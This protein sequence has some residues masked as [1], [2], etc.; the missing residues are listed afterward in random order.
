VIR[1]FFVTLRRSQAGKPYFHR[2]VLDSLGLRRRLACTE[3]P[4]NSIIRGMLRKV[5]LCQPPELGCS[6]VLLTPPWCC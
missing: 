1:T 6:H 4:N 3:K 5:R 2:K